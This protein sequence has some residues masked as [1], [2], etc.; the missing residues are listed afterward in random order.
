VRKT[1]IVRK[2]RET[3]IAL[4]L[5]IDGSGTCRIRSGIGFFDHMLENFAKHGQ[6]DIIATMKADLHVDQHHMI[7]DTGIVLGQAFDKALKARRGIQRAGFFVFPMDEA[8]AL[9]ALDISGRPLVRM[10]AKFKRK[11]AGEFNTDLLEDFF[12]GFSRALKATLHIKILCGRSDH[13]KL[14][15]VFKAF[16]KAL[17]QACSKGPRAHTKVPSTKGIV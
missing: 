5:K 16:G 2:T 11:T 12:S 8:L 10:N 17:K 7:E 15:S 6:F 1:H 9:V 3:R 4:D 13:H 14:E